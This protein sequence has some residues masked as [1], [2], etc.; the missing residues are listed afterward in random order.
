MMWSFAIW[1]A[2]HLAVIGTA[3]AILFDGAIILL[4][5]GGSAAQDAKKRQL[6]GEDWHAWIAQTGFVPFSRGVAGPGPVALV[7]GTL[8]FFIA[9]W[10]HPIPAGFWRWIG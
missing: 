10:V 4:A 7:G 1:A 5:L 9:T 3:K 8:L 6:M 2:V